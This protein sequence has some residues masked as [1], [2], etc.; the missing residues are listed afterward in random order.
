MREF[1]EFFRQVLILVVIISLYW[2][3]NVPLAALAYKVRNGA[4]PIP[5]A[6]VPFWGRSLFAAVGMAVLSLS[7]MGFDKALTSAGIPVGMVHLL[8]CLFF[9]PLGSWWMFT[10]FALEDVWEGLSTLLLY[11]FLPGIVLVLL[12]LLFKFELPY[13]LDVRTWWIVEVPSM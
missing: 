11:V 8:M 2:P 4:K 12:K 13:F 9:L 1:F 10:V 5:L 6:T 7:L 3:F